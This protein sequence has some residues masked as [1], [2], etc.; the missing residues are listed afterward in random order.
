MGFKNSLEVIHSDFFRSENELCQFVA[1]EHSVI[2]N[3]WVIRNSIASH[4]IGSI[5]TL[6]NHHQS[7]GHVMTISLPRIALTTGEPA[8]IGLDITLQLATQPIDA[9]I[10]AWADP[11]ILQ[12][13]AQQLGSNVELIV[14][15]T[16][17]PSIHRPYQLKVVPVSVARPVIAGQLNAAN[18]HYVLTQ[19]QQAC[20]RCVTHEFDALVTAPVHKAIIND[21]GIPFSGH[22]EFFAH[23]TQ[24]AQ[25]VMMLATPGLRVALVTTHL[26]LNQVSSAITAVK[27]ITVIRILHH[28]LQTKFGIAHPC[29]SVCG[30]NPHAGE[31]GHLGNEENLIIIP[32]L[33]QLRAEG[34]QLIGPLPADT[35]FTP[36][37]LT[38]IDAVLTMYHDQG[39]PVL[40]HLGFGH[41]VNITLGLPIIRT[42][43]DHGTAL[44]L[45][46][47]GQ[48]RAES[49]RYAVQ[50]AM[51]M[52]SATIKKL[53]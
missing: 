45:A 7:T 2:L 6:Y 14:K 22:T 25:V 53:N 17:S 3:Q 12:Q 30:L 28:D 19:L 21:A 51:E 41:A 10:V 33:Q 29:I 20:Q 8:G 36:R 18:A 4:L 44:E 24:T 39:L 27:L 37:A 35:A 38:G 48:A 50:V 23:Q 31:A 40:K 34:L 26:P 11:N 13:R 1:I 16:H 46:G 47:T 52:V 5:T 49:L 42:S 32:V 9:D 15:E 43:V